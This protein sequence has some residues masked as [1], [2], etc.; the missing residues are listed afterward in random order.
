MGYFIP[1]D[2]QRSIDEYDERR[3]DVNW[4]DPE[5]DMDKD[6]HHDYEAIDR[7]VRKEARSGSPKCLDLMVFDSITPIFEQSS[8]TKT[9][10]AKANAMAMLFMSGT[11][12]NCDAMFLVHYRKTSEGQYG[13]ATKQRESLSPLELARAGQNIDV[14]LEMAR[15][16]RTPEGKGA[17]KY[18]VQIKWYRARPDAEF[19]VLWDDV[20]DFKGMR[21]RIE[22][23]LDGAE[24]TTEAPALFYEYGLDKPFPRP[25]GNMIPAVQMAVEYFIEKDD[26]K[27]YAF[28]DPA[29][30]PVK[31]EGTPGTNGV[32]NYALNA[33]NAIKTGKK[34][35]DGYQKPA[36][37]KEFTAVWVRYVTD[38]ITANMGLA[39]QEPEPEPEVQQE[40]AF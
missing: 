7:E 1:I 22:A 23:L 18:G 35:E 32:Y 40:V 20:S 25:K 24:E 4:Y 19:P 10:G 33:Y 38:N 37:A 11:R 2:G 26:K 36:N 5:L 3:P 31:K 12:A 15:E 34:A 14:I 8:R 16:K 6:E 29:E 27:Y 30:T 28:G 39:E 9:H 13:Q 21:Q 17:G